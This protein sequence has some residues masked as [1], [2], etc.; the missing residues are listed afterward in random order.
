M[1][2][3][4]EIKK[5]ILDAKEQ[6][7][8]LSGLNSTSKVSIYGLWAGIVAVIA[9]SLY[10]FFEQFKLEM[11][12][13]VNRQKVGTLQWYRD[14]ALAYRHGFPLDP[15]TGE[16]NTAGY[17]DEEIEAAT[18]VD[19][20]AV[21]ELE[22]NNRKRLFIKL[23]K[24]TNNELVPL[25][26]A[27]KLAVDQYF[28]KRKFAGTKIDII[29]NAPD[30]LRLSVVFYYDP[31]VMDENGVRLDGSANTPVQDVIRDYLRN[32]RFNGEFTIAEL[33]DRLQN[34]QGCADREAY[35]DS[36]EGNFLTPPAYQ[37]ITAN[38]IANSGYMVITDDNLSIQFIPKNVIL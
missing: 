2:T 37:I 10:Q 9:W 20:A 16:P 25:S 15:L 14:V 22:L 34:I 23:A 31:L 6:Q 21:E 1:P 27:E 30:D 7:T 32:L 3:I 12:G 19:R 36:A 8:A 13:L 26:D 29:S 24:E 11:D 28:A 33:Q 35:I 18:I 17:T 4:Q 5:S 38:Y